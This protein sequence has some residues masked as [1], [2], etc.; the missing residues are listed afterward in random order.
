MTEDPLIPQKVLTLQRVEKSYKMDKRQSP[1]EIFNTDAIQRTFQNVLTTSDEA[2]SHLINSNQIL[3]EKC[4]EKVFREKNQDLSV[5]I[6][7]ILTPTSV[8]FKIE[9]TWQGKT[10]ELSLLEQDPGIRFDSCFLDLLKQK[11]YVDNW[12]TKNGVLRKPFELTENNFIDYKRFEEKI[13]IKK[14]VVSGYGE[15]DVV[16]FSVP[17]GPINLEHGKEWGKY[18]IFNKLNEI[19]FPDIF[20]NFKIEIQNEMKSKGKLNVKIPSQQELIEEMMNISQVS[21]TYENFAQHGP[22][23][24][25]YWFLQ[26]GIDLQ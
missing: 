15:F 13:V 26:A 1:E 10:T 20:E 21:Q 22:I 3:I 2:K 23:L 25:I 16:K 5:K 8:D 11:G 9:I 6:I 12:D 7:S 17:I 18:L 19:C 14:P 24:N 4:Y